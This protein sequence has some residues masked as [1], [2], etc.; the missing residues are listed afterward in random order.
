MTGE[1]TARE[2]VLGKYPDAFADDDG[3]WIYIRTKETVTKR[4]PTC[5]QDWTHKVTNF[6][7]TL[8]SA[9]NESLAWESAA[10]RLG[11]I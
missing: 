9:G 10:Q 2:L 8:G 4:C 1:L 3:D 6:G 11:L 7:N 5:G